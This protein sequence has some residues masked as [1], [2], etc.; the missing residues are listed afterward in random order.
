MPSCLLILSGSCSVGY[1]DPAL[2]CVIQHTHMHMHTHIA[3][4]HTHTHIAHTH[5]HTRALAHMHTHAHIFGYVLCPPWTLNRIQLLHCNFYR[6]LTL[7]SNNIALLSICKSPPAWIYTYCR[8]LL[9]HMNTHLAV[10]LS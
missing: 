2:L 1:A 3:R 9:T 5:T 7:A 4:T 10:A 6:L 8:C